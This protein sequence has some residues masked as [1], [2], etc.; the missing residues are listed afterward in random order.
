[1]LQVEQNPFLGFMAIAGGGDL[2]RVC[3]YVVFS[4]V[5]DQGFWH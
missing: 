2:L 4:R 3:R 1:M 5:Y